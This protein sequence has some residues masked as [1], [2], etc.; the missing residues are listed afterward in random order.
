MAA[1]GQLSISE[2][3]D[4]FE[5]HSWNVHKLQ[6]KQL[7]EAVFEAEEAFSAHADYRLSLDGLRQSFS[8]LADNLG[9]RELANTILPFGPY[10]VDI[11]HPIVMS[12]QEY[13]SGLIICADRVARM[14]F[15]LKSSPA[16]SES[17]QSG[18]NDSIPLPFLS[19][20]LLAADESQSSAS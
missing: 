19:A 2:F 17:A 9:A 13:A 4:W 10:S 16:I 6:D 15:G 11:Q 20:A 14:V 8:A 18:R 7:L 5:Q 3:E 1:D 12:R